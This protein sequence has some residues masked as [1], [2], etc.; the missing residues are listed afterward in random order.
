M[1]NNVLKYLIL[2]SFLVGGI[3]GI[4]ASIPYIGGY[5]LF[6]AL[7]LTS[8]LVILLL[9]MSGKADLTTPKDSIING[10]ISGFF[11][12]ITFSFAYSFVIAMLYFGAKYT[13]N[14]FLTAIVINSPI[15][16][17]LSFVVF[18]GVLTATT[19]AFSGF[20]TYYVINLIRDIY[21]K[22]QADKD[23]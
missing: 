17:F 1:D 3:F 4:L 9:I 13:S 8:P 15:W 23:R 11:A 22:K 18:I 5:V 12:N 19:N 7:F 21:E 2:N 14:Y 10:A 6:F 16:L 20:M